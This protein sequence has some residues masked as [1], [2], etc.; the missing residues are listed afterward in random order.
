M[1]R[2]DQDLTLEN[3]VLLIDTNMFVRILSSRDCIHALPLRTSSKLTQFPMSKPDMSR[4]KCI[5]KF[6]KFEMANTLYKKNY[7]RKEIKKERTK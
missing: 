2:P 4:E 3:L 5:N 1:I 7:Y 6:N